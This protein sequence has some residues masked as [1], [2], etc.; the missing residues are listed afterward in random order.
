[1]IRSMTAF[2]RSSASSKG[3]N[4][5]VELR[6][7]NH[8]YFEFS[9]KCPPALNTLEPS[10]REML[11]FS[12]KRGKMTVNIIQDVGG[13]GKRLKTMVVDPSAVQYYGSAIK[14]LKKDVKLDGEVSISDFLRLP[15]IFS[16]E[17][18]EE[19]PQ[20]AWKKIKPV[21]SKV[22]EEAI[23]AKEKEG[24]KL[25]TDIHKRL[26]SIGKS[27]D[28]IEKL[29]KGRS[30]AVYDRISQRVEELL[31]EKQMDEE[32]VHREVAFMAERSDITE[33]IVRLKSHLHLFDERLASKTEIGRELDFICQEMNR[34]INTISS[35]SQL[36]DIATHV[37]A[38][39]GEIEKIREQVQNIE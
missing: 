3:E 19:D 17:S 6:T 4:W 11:H 26:G 35:K 33:E 15:G 8:R 36:F 29:A 9:L 7:L 5:I 27:V 16:A 37:I 38:V 18:S 13:N 30:Q 20:K 21:L 2:A 39:K 14:K 22:I 31:R 12:I 34:E 32:R 1:M 10:V 25:S 24:K 23:V 28:Q